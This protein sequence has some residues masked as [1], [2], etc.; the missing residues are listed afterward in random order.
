[1][2][3]ARN[4]LTNDI[5]KTYELII[6]IKKASIF[7]G[8]LPHDSYVETV[9]DGEIY[10]TTTPKNPPEW[11][12]IVTKPLPNNLNGG[13]AILFAVYKKRWTSPGYKLV[14]TAEFTLEEL[15]DD[16]R[17]G[18]KFTDEIFCGSILKEASLKGNKKNLTLSGTIFLGIEI[19]SHLIMDGDFKKNSSSSTMQFFTSSDKASKPNVFETNR[20]IVDVFYPA[21]IKEIKKHK[22]S[23]SQPLKRNRSNERMSFLYNSDAEKERSDFEGTD[24]CRN[25]E[26]SNSRLRCISFHEV[27]I[28]LNVFY[29]AVILYDCCRV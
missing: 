13:M 7:G 8:G 29:S 14:G 24:S 15:I 16:V 23:L 18:K 3:S 26:D 22:R 1:M 28:I 9:I 19:K 5:L 2:E 12:K 10:D 27:R 6:E 17:N 25:S 11:N 4:S 21:H 20:A